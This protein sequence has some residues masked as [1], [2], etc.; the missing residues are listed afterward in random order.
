MARWGWADHKDLAG[1]D[2]GLASVHGD[3]AFY[4]PHCSGIKANLVLPRRKK[5][6]IKGSELATTGLSMFAAPNVSC[7]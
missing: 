5:T 4:E 2:P 6:S 1:S 3:R 7:L